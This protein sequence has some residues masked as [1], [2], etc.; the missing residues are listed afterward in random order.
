M[1]AFMPIADALKSSDT[2][3]DV[4]S[5]WRSCGLTR[6]DMDL[7][8]RLHE[9]GP[10]S[11][12]SSFEAAPQP[13]ESHAPGSLSDGPSLRGQEQRQLCQTPAPLVRHRDAAAILSDSQT[14]EA[15]VRKRRVSDTQTQDLMEAV[16][17][18]DT[19]GAFE[20]PRGRTAG[21][22]RVARAVAGWHMRRGEMRLVL[23]PPSL[24]SGRRLEALG[25]WR[26]TR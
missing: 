11:M 4:P 18:G 1:N 2:C 9:A 8:I 25:N 21:I 23:W 10:V 19:A 12:T 14:G 15:A 13:H 16:P 17:D 24:T 22:S 26:A 6:E 20:A 7:L 3:P 5:P